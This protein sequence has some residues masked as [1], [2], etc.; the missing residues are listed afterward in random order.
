MQCGGVVGIGRTGIGDED[1]GCG[2][3][4]VAVDFGSYAVS[5]GGIGV[6]WIGCKL[7]GLQRDYEDS[8]AG[9]GIGWRGGNNSKLYIEA[10]LLYQVRNAKRKVGGN[11]D[12]LAGWSYALAAVKDYCVGV[13]RLV[14]VL[15]VGGDGIDGETLHDAEAGCAAE[16]GLP[17]Q[18]VVLLALKIAAGKEATIKPQRRCTPAVQQGRAIAQVAG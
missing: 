12:E 1:D 9:F 11:L 13:D 10:L 17:L 7:H 6:D 15:A 4:D 5:G 16:V 8:G 18:K 14:G 3:N 2:F